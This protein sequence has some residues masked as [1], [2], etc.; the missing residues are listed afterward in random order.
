MTN[1]SMNLRSW[2]EHPFRARLG[3]CSS[4]PPSSSSSSTPVRVSSTGITPLAWAVVAGDAP[5]L[6]WWERWLAARGGS[7]MVSITSAMTRMEGTAMA[8]KGSRQ[9]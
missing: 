8:T 6:G 3:P 2:M 1:T 9:P 4:S 5:W 7:F